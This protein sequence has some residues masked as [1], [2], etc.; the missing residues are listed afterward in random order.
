M[1]ILSEF[2]DDFEVREVFVGFLDLPLLT[3][4]GDWLVWVK[5]RF[6]GIKGMV[7]HL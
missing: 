7:I 5:T 4:S 2:R 1:S 3:V 6:N